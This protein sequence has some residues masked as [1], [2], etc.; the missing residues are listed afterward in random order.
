M[1]IW[2][3]PPG[4]SHLDPQ[5]IQHQHSPIFQITFNQIYCNHLSMI[6]DLM[7]SA[8]YQM[9]RNLH[10]CLSLNCIVLWDHFVITLAVTIWG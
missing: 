6:K 3:A 2:L 9:R 8:Y 5:L 4:Y 7:H 1:G 10:N